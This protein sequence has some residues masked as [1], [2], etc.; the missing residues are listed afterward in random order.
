MTTTWIYSIYSSVSLR[1]KYFFDDF[2]LFSLIYS[3]SIKQFGKVVTVKFRLT[4]IGEPY[5]KQKIWLKQHCESKQ[6]EGET[7]DKRSNI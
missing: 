4:K 2:Y 1:Y 5:R 3:S 6:R 7:L